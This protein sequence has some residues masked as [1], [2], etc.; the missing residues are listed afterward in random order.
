MLARLDSEHHLVG[1]QHSTHRVYATGERL[2]KNDHVGMHVLMVDGQHAPRAAETSL[3]LVGDHQHVILAAQLAHALQVA[4]RWHHDSGLTL[5]WLKHEAT[6]VRVGGE[7]CLKRVEVAVRYEVHMRHEWAE[8][9]AAARVARRRACA[10]R[11]S[12]KVVLA[13]EHRRFVCRDALHIVTPTPCK[14]HGRFT[15]LDAGV[16]REHAIEAKILSHKLGVLP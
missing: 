1:A 11:S 14:L 4:I 3:H 5:D 6:H 10:Q 8:A 12:P 13:E 15:T 2:A 9:S 16:H 7:R